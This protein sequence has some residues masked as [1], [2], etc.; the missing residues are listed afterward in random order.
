[1]NTI[2]VS[3]I[4]HPSTVFGVHGGDGRLYWKR[5]ATGSHLHAPWEGFEWV[6]LGPGDAV[7]KHTH[8][9]TEEVFYFLAGSGVVGVDGQ[10]WRVREG[11]VVLTP[12]NSWQTVRNDGERDLEYLVI[13]VFPPA[14]STLLPP[15]I[16]SDETETETEHAG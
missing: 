1:V 4:A 11:E 16:P 15:R 14:I 5:L 12:L 6:A 2:I 3:D 8:S 7:G 10:E 9:H 13:E